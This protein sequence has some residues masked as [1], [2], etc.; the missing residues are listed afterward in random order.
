MTLHR[1]DTSG[2]MAKWVLEL[3]EFDLVFHPR[4][5][6][7]AQVL[8]DFVMECTIPEEKFEG[9]DLMDEDLEN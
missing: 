9:S 6:I 1:P 5:S 4:P 2:K 7:K 3:F 8:V